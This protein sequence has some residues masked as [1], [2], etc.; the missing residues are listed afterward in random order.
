M[1]RFFMMMVMGLLVSV[2][3]FA[4]GIDDAKQQGLIGERP[5]G[6]VGIVNTATP[7]VDQL[8]RSIN[9]K[10]RAEYDRIAV[11]TSQSRTIVEQLAAKKAYEMT[12]AG[13]YLMRG[14]GTWLQQR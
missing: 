9:R 13:Q 14:D 8:V 2:P 11:E 7:E 4:L 6:Y 12:P 3:A 5:D 1:R 10:R